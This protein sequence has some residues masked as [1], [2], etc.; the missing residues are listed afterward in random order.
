MLAIGDK[1]A[2]FKSTNAGHLGRDDAKLANLLEPPVRRGI[3]NTRLF[4]LPTARVQYCNFY[5]R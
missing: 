1:A 3:L 4:I 5:K 2:G